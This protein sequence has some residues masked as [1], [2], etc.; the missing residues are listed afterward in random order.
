M[1]TDSDTL[2]RRRTRPLPP[3]PIPSHTLAQV[4]DV[5]G[6]VQEDTSWYP[7]SRNRFRESVVTI[8]SVDTIRTVLPA[9]SSTLDL[10]STVDGG[11]VTLPSGLD[12]APSSSAVTVDHNPP[13][14]EHLL[15]PTPESPTTPTTTMHGAGSQAQQRQRSSFVHH[16]LYLKKN[17]AEKPWATLRLI[18]RAPLPN[19]KQKTP[20]FIGGDLVKGV[21]E[22]ELESPMSVQSISLNVKGKLTTTRCMERSSLENHDYVF[23]EKLHELYSKKA[24]GGPGNWGQCNTSRNRK[25]DGKMQGTYHIPFS[26]TFPTEVTVGGGQNLLP[27]LTY[28]LPPSHLERDSNVT[29]RYEIGLTI[30]HGKLKMNSR[31]STNIVYTPKLVAPPASG[32][33]Q[34]AYQEG[35]LLP[36]PGRDPGGWH[37][38]SPVA[39]SGKIQDRITQVSCALY[40]ANPLWYTRGT[41]LPCC[42]K[43]SGVDFDLLEHLASP[44]WVD[45]QLVRYISFCKDGDYPSSPSRDPANEAEVEVMGTAVWWRPPKSDEPED[46]NTRWLEGE[47]HLPMDLH[48]SS[49]Y[50]RFIIEYYVEMM[51]FLSHNF[52][53]DIESGHQHPVI[54]QPVKIATFHQYGPVPVA[55]TSRDKSEQRDRRDVRRAEKS[56]NDKVGF[57][58]TFSGP[59]L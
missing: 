51:P 23:L 30:G 28:K 46:N 34:T 48:P 54:R 7:P 14:Y 39:L 26:F 49:E 36:G 35:A 24:H 56:V 59:L 53:I 33:R 43:L 21:L 6:E 20:R 11:A 40:L 1:A 32:G 18:S 50:P 29:V 38:V 4:S 16:R 58:K 27:T 10:A 3:I 12:C 44:K 22:L 45:L 9:Y 37:G 5:R 2:P 57:M 41:V 13:R 25:S 15:L 8:A 17:G 52:N 42:L 47:I 55:F 31:V 19:S